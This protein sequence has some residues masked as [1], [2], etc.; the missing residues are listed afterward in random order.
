M[1]KFLQRK[2]T[3][4]YAKSE[5]II[6]SKWGVRHSNPTLFHRVRNLL[7]I[8]FSSLSWYFKT[9]FKMRRLKMFRNAF[10]TIMQRLLLQNT[11]SKKKSVSQK[12]SQRWKFSCQAKIPFMH[13]Q[14]DSDPFFFHDLFWFLLKRIRKYVNFMK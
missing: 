11:Y 8:P 4:K 12:Y 7:K 13:I 3:R 10:L 5:Y 9:L 6:N 1:W 2:L 14:K